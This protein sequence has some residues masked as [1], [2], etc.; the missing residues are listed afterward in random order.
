MTPS[1]QNLNAKLSPRPA[2]NPAAKSLRIDWRRGAI[3]G[4]DA[5]VRIIG[6]PSR[7]RGG[8]RLSV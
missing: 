5:P 8:Y 2:P 1:V 3:R 4:S 6:A 7:L